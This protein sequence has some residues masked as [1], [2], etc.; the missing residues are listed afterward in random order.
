MGIFLPVRTVD[1]QRR[2]L[3]VRFYYKWYW[4]MSGVNVIAWRVRLALSRYIVCESVSVKVCQYQ[5][6]LSNGLIE[7]TDEQHILS[8]I[9]YN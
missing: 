9:F 2:Q 3:V 7:E 6:I 1:Q 4:V 5:V 8:N